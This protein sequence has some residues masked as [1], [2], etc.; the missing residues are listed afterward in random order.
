MHIIRYRRWN[1]WKKER[2][3]TKKTVILN[4]LST[5]GIAGKKGS[6]PGKLLSSFVTQF[7]VASQVKSSDCTKPSHPIPYLNIQS[8]VKWK[9][10]SHVQLFATPWTIQSMEFSRPEY[11]TEEPFPSPGD[12]PN[13]G[14][15]PRSPA[16]QVDS[17]PVEPQRKPTLSEHFVCIFFIT[18]NYIIFYL[19]TCHPQI[20]DNRLLRARI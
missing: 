15:E 9:L 17:L 19:S 11:W 1:Q 14:I 6:L 5:L 16:L 3:K 13:L 7:K 2:R 18:E 4:Y 8:E 10:F 20:L 12:L